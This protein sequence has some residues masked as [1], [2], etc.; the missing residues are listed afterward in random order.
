MWDHIPNG[1]YTKYKSISTSLSKATLTYCI[2]K[3]KY[4][5]DNTRTHTLLTNKEVMD[6]NILSI[7][8][9]P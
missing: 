9:E 7:V 3:V 8:G 4:N 6:R 2:A 1:I 5:N